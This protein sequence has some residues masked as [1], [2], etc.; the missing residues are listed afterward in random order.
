MICLKLT[1]DLESTESFEIRIRELEYLL[2]SERSRP[3]KVV[4]GITY[5]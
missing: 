3:A 2:Q 5:L 4:V 1:I